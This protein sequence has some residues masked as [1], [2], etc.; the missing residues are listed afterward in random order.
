MFLSVI[1]PTYNRAA[2]LHRVYESICQQSLKKIDREYIFEW[3]VIDDGSEDETE[4]LV[5]SWQEKEDFPIVY[6]YQENSGKAKALATAIESAKGE[7]TLIADSDDRFLPETFELFY[8]TIESFSDE[9]KEKCGGIGVLCVDEKGERVGCDYPIQK[10]FVHVKEVVF[11]WSDIGLNETW[12]LL[13]TQNLRYAFLDIPDEAKEL[14]FIPESFFWNRI[15]FELDTYSYPINKPLRIYYRNEED[16][17]SHNIH[18]RYPES[19]L[20]ESRWF[21]THYW[22][23]AL[24]FPKLYLKHLVKMVYFTT[25]INMQRFVW[26]R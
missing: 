14:K 21:V 26:N 8:T 7:W 20:F 22:P 12:A 18:Q 2:K 15:A 9:E 19:F 4:K 3:I 10:E 24:Q 25:I 1:T 6:K 5:K 16:N 17:I 13:K 11:Q 23:L